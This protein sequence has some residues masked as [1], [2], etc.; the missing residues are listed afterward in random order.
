MITGGFVNWQRQIPMQR[1]NDNEFKFSLDLQ[2]GKYQYKF[3]VDGNWRCA[4][5]QPKVRD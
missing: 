3:I 1:V 5:D 4:D 2:P